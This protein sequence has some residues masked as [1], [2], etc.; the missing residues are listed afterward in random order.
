MSGAGRADPSRYVRRI[1]VAEDCLD[2]PLVREILDATTLPW[3][4]RAGREPSAGEED[5]SEGLGRGKRE[6][7]LKRQRGRFYRDCPGTRAY[8][9]CGYKV[10]HVG[11]NCPMDCVYCILQAYLNEPNLV[12]YVNIEDLFLELT[13]VFANAT[14]PVLRIGTGEFTDSLALDPI[15]RASPRLVRF[16]AGQARAVLELKTKSVNIDLLEPLDHGRRTVL[17]WSLNTEAVAAREEIRAAPIAQRLAAARRAAAWG[18]PLAFHFDP[19]L[20]VPGWEDGYRQVI[21]R[22]FDAV[23]AEAIVWISLGGLRFLPAL[24][25][26]AHRRHPGSRIFY[27]EWVT[28]LDDKCRYFRELRTGIYQ[29]LVEEIRRFADPDTCVYFCMENDQVWRDVFGFTPNQRGGLSAMLD[30]AARKKC[31]C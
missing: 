19:V 20:H 18:Y 17:A 2:L 1:V 13:S 6:L 16:F 24:K 15:T 10:L 7:W 25:A 5:W 8:R 28:G 12:F 26:I 27:H 9:C 11:D 4:V 31:G 23:P 3:E 30:E 22:L 21:R 14:E 29:V